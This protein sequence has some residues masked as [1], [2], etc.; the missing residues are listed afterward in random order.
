MIGKVVLLIIL[1][2]ANQALN[3]DC[4][5]TLERQIRP[6]NGMEVSKAKGPVSPSGPCHRTYVP[7][8]GP[9]CKIHR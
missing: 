3:G 4:S 6:S 5:R 8:G 1:I 2:I 7:V 9:P